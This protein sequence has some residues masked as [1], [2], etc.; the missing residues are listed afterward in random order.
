MDKNNY[1]FIIYVK[2]RFL[3]IYSVIFV[4]YVVS[5]FTYIIILKNPLPEL[6]I[7][8]FN[9]FMLQDKVSFNLGEFAIEPIFNNQ[10]LW[11][12]TYEWWFY[13]IFFIHF[14]ISKELSINK[15]ILFSFGISFLG[16]ITYYL[17][18]NQVSSILL[19]YY[20]WFSGGVLYYINKKS[21]SIKR[22]K[23]FLIIGFIGLILIYIVLF[24]LNNEYIASVV[25]PYIKLRHYIS[26]LVFIL[27]L[28]L[29]N[30]QIRL[31]LK[32]SLINKILSVFIKLAPISFSIY[33]IHYPIMEVFETININIYLK[34]LCTIVIT[35]FFA[36]IAEVKLYKYLRRKYL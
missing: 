3:R 16:M 18:P 26:A 30:K 23:N 6:K 11:S 19:Y 2:H 10:P 20:M 8:L 28:F 35:L 36:Y 4:A 14:K 21:T 17:Y 15:N 31:F 33:A 1:P 5:I 27:I 13:M 32:I 12:L 34:L 7:I 25:F 9:I 24:I 29:F 22:E